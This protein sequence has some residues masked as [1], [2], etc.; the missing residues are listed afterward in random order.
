M[1]ALAALLLAVQQQQP[2]TFVTAPNGRPPST[3]SQRAD[4]R[5][6]ARLDEAAQKLVAKGVLTYVNNSRDT[7]REMYVHQYLN[8]FRPGSQ[9]S[10]VDEREGRVRFQHLRDPDYGYERFTAP[11]NVNGTDVRVDY[12]GAPDSTVAH[13]VLPSPAAPGDTV[14]VRFA[15]EARASTTPRRQGHRGRSWDFSQWYPKVAVYDNGGWQPYAL[16]PAGEFYGEFGSFDVT[17]ILRDDQVVAGTG[18]VV[19]GDPGWERV[20]K[21]G[22]VYSPSLAPYRVPAATWPAWRDS[23]GPGEKAVRFHAENIHEFAWSTS[24]DYRYEGGIYLRPRGEVPAPPGRAVWDTVAVHVLYRPGDEKSWGDGAALARTKIALEWLEHVYGPYV[25]P[26]IVNLHRL[27]GGG[28]EFPMM[29]MNGSAGQGLILH[30]GGHIFTFGILANSEWRSG[31]MDEGLTSYQSSWAEGVT[32]QDRA[33]RGGRDSSVFRPRGYRRLAPR[34]SE[35]DGLQIAQYRLDMLGRAQ[36]VGTRADLF[37]DFGIYNEMIYSRAELMYGALRDAIGD[38]A[39]VAFMHR[40]Y[41]DWAL[42]HVDE[43][44][45][46][47]SAELASGQELGWFF[48]QWVHRTGLTDYAL[49]KVKTSRNADGSWTTRGRVKRRA[50]YR[51]PPPLGVKTSAGW[52]IARGSASADDQWIEVRT[53]EKPTAVR[54]DPLR[55]TEDWDRRND[56]RPSL[57]NFWRKEERIVEQ[58]FDWPFLDQSSRDKVIDA[59]TPIAWYSTANHLVAGIRGRTNYQGL[60]DRDE[61]GVVLN[62][63]APGHRGAYDWISSPR[64]QLWW[65]HENPTIPW[66]GR[67]LMGLRTTAWTLDGAAGGEISYSR[68]ASRFYFVRGTRTN[69][70]V[71]ITYTAP[72]GFG[73]LPDRWEDARVGE[74]KA[75]Q[76]IRFARARW[77]PEVGVSVAAGVARRNF[78]GTSKTDGYGRGEAWVRG[79]RP[80]G[81]DS[82]AILSLRGF[83]GGATNS[84]PGQRRIFLGA[85]DPYQT[86][87]N[88]FVR[89]RGGLLAPEHVAT[90]PLGG[91]GLRGYD[92]ALT[93]G[94]PVLALNVE[95][96]MRI[97]PFALGSRPLALWLTGFAD[98]AQQDGLTAS[99]LADAGLGVMLRGWIFDRDVRVRLDMPLYVRHGELAAAR[100]GLL[101]GVT[102]GSVNDVSTSR[103]QLTLGSFW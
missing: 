95:Q 47:T 59:T 20:K 57:W 73:Y 21:L 64:V 51:E 63:V 75:D 23:A 71:G 4:Y 25:Y 78:S 69:R 26:Q 74:L 88:H 19:S 62:R 13:F 86:L 38:S 98:V 52:T 14:M 16:R 22:A 24:P 39:F 2:D 68:D 76:T 9:W 3:A 31:W 92:P 93:A 56:V 6:V 50:E 81:R 58:R 32:P 102:Q 18:L 100:H 15:W 1:I 77:S 36:P 96:G 46:R 70:S 87:F 54:L 29:M 11:P 60:V 33:R 85:R 53:A 28:T 30:E 55:T 84:T 89:P 44:A 37:S 94:D 103:V 49:T 91:A 99:P 7:L 72:R 80:F 40:Y 35:T 67:P 61:L 43:R 8:A 65:I 97:V 27:D 82:A 42:Q 41:S 79:A 48:D 90:V 5:I 45:M 66:R 10:A 17:L 34:M 101:D 83:V 12:P